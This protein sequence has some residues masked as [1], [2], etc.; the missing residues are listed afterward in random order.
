MRGKG[1]ELVKQNVGAGCETKIKNL[2]LVS[3]ASSTFDIC[4]TNLLNP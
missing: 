3:K 2:N 4:V 1:A